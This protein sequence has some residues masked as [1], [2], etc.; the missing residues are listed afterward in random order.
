MQRI[1]LAIAGAAVLCAV[2][3]LL[4]Q[5]AI[6]RGLPVAELV[7]LAAIATLML[8]ALSTFLS[9][10]AF[11]RSNEVWAELE[12]LSRSM[13]A[14]IKDVSARGDRDAAVLGNLSATV[15]RKLDALSGKRSGPASADTS[16]GKRQKGL[17]A[18][19]ADD[20]STAASAGLEAALRRIAA[21]ETADLAL[22]P[23]IAA[24]RGAA[25]GFEVHFHVQPEDGDPVDIRR[26]A[27]LGGD[28]D[29]AAL[30]RLGLVSATEAARKRPG[31]ITEKTPLHVAVSEALLN[32]G[33]EFA[34][35]LDVFRLH[36]ALARAIVI[37]LPPEVAEAEELQAPLEVLA[38]LGIRL[39]AEDWS[40]SPEAL[41]QIKAKK[42]R[43][44]KISADR[45]L[46]RSGRRAAAS[47]NDL[48]ASIA[49]AQM[50]VI[51]TDVASDEDAVALIE[52]GV[53]LMTGERL[54]PPRR[55]KE[56]VHASIAS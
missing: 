53:D 23:I 47:G 39:A 46:D 41:D 49:E 2:A 14:A 34:A 35:V 15:S 1:L 16:G 10:R 45:L 36:P 20:G 29:P 4:L 17:R 30:E 13:D 52:R 33:L 26:P 40:G 38:G 3:T 44:I 48:I 28:P 11:T 21:S 42:C 54:S 25:G 43:Y 19:D 31:E 55:I 50:E 56:G 27:S 24:G 32:D 8:A 51:A 12:R 37:S 18:T 5:L 9:Y 6:A 7:L 22:Q